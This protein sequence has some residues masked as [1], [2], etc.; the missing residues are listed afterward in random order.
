MVYGCDICQDVCPWNRGIEKRRAGEG[1]D[2]AEPFVSLREWLEEDGAA[3]R[4]R[5]RRLY[6]PRNDPRWLRRNALVAL[7]NAGCQP[8][9]PPGRALPR[10]GRRDA[11]RDGCVGAAR[12]AERA[13]DGCCKA[14]AA[15]AERVDRLRARPRAAQPGRGARWRS[16]RRS[17]SSARD[18]SA[19]ELRRLLE[20]AVAAGRDMERLLADPELFSSS[21]G[22][23]RSPT[24]LAGLRGDR[25]EVDVEAGAGGQGRSRCAC[26]RRSRTSSRT[27]CVRE[28]G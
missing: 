6:V 28:I 3:L 21:R 12:L 26:G 11:A 27:A 5:Y 13:H 7:G 18:V 2:G 4:E 24:V 17:R 1:R 19:P 15:T 22:P 8:T 14:A 16:R 23:S 20:L 10:R 9:T 25:V